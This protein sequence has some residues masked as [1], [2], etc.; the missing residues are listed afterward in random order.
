MN[1]NTKIPPA[2]VSFAPFFL[3]FLIGLVAGAVVDK[4]DRKTIIVV[5]DF[6]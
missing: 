2:K 1:V 6:S 5:A 3:T 4:Y